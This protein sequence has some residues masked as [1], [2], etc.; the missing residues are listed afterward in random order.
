VYCPYMG[1]CVVGGFGARGDMLFPSGLG[2]VGIAVCV[3][4]LIYV[5][6]WR[7]R[8]TPAWAATVLVGWVPAGG[9][10][11]GFGRLGGVGWVMMVLAVLCGAVLSVSAF[12]LVPFCVVLGGG[13]WGRV[14]CRLRGVVFSWRARLC[15]CAWSCG[16]G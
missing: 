13:W 8:G 4:T 16:V 9:V 6:D 12:R 7:S 14:G 15:V 5:P 11:L 1:P 2:W 10:W 3:P